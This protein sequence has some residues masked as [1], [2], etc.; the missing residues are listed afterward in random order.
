MAFDFK[1]EYKEFYMSKIKPSILT[2]PPMNY[3]VVRITKRITTEHNLSLFANNRGQ[4]LFL[5]N[6]K[7]LLA[8]QP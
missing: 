7:L 2:V 8:E 6:R 5:S 3:I 1:K 4:A